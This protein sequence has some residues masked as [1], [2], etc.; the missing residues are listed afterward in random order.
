MQHADWTKFLY[1][2]QILSIIVLACSRAAVALLV[3]SLEPF[4][5]ILVACRGVL[6]II[7]LWAAAAV[8][9]LAVQCDPPYTSDSSLGRCVNQEVLFIILAVCSIITDLA[10]ILLPIALVW[11][12]QITTMKR[13]H[14]SALFG[15][16]IM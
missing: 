14:I 10:V 8:I 3:L 11:N 4:K 12:V 9:S 15:L 5:A 1:A 16:R 7:G 13:L 6:G 2:S